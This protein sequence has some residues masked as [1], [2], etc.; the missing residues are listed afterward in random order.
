V[1]VGTLL[2]SPV[3]AAQIDADE[4]RSS[5]V[6]HRF[7]H[8][9][10][11]DAEF[12]MRL[13][14]G[15]N[16]NLF[17]SSRGAGGDEF[18]MD[19][20]L[21]PTILGKGFA[22]AASDEGWFRPTLAARPQ[23]RLFES[24]A[25]LVQLTGVARGIIEDHYG[26]P[27]SRVY[28]VGTSMGGHHV[29]WLLEDF[30]ELYDGAISFAGLNSLWEFLRGQAAL[31]RNYQL[32][33]SRLNEIIAAA[34]ANPGWDPQVTPLSPPLTPEQ[35]AALR[36]LYSMPASLACGF[37]YDQG[38]LRGSES[39]WPAGYS[40]AIG[41]LQEM[42]PDVDPT[43]DPNG[44]GVRSLDELKMWDLAARPVH[45]ENQAR[46]L[47]LTGKVRRPLIL[48]HGAADPTVSPQ[49]SLAY[50]ELVARNTGLADDVVRVYLVPN[51]GHGTYV[52]FLGPATDALEAWVETGAAPGV[53]GGLLPR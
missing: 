27:A 35:I 8:G 1:A 52:P 38:R 20:T 41:A 36:A 17:V 25:R 32:I 5:P 51:F 50:K 45:V 9:R 7:I 22:Y 24:R 6:Q 3:R 28:L 42:V 11:G 53:I 14:V 18:V 40:T 16:G 49:E 4:T 12:Q 26:Q 30:P 13:P 21:M 47:D 39:R 46:K 48:V 31:V 29:R 33:Q 10:L 23:D 19:Q 37:E 34:T 15:W 43:Y 44:D 2:P